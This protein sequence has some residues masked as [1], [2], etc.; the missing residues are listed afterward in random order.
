MN[1]KSHR[2]KREKYFAGR[3]IPSHFSPESLLDALST[4]PGKPSLMV[5]DEVS[6]ILRAASRKDYLSDL[7]EL[8]LKLYDGDSVEVYTLKRGQ[9]IVEEPTVM[10]VGASTLENLQK[11]ISLED[12]DTGL[13]TRF[14]PI[15]VGLE[16]RLPFKPLQALTPEAAREFDGL[17]NRLALLSMEFEKSPHQ[18]TLAPEALE[19]FNQ[20]LKQLDD[21]AV[22]ATDLE[23]KIY[24]RLGWHIL[25]AALIFAANRQGK[26]LREVSL[27]DLRRAIAW[28]EKIARSYQ[29]LA[30][31]LLEGPN[32]AIIKRALQYLG[33]RNGRCKRRD[34][35]RALSLDSKTMNGVEE[36]LSQRELIVIEKVPFKNQPCLYW[37][38]VK[39]EAKGSETRVSVDTLQSID[40]LSPDQ[41]RGK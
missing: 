27:L 15:V 10:I 31:A 16:D 8:L 30:Q 18:V 41:I 38:L 3:L 17:A 22:S 2:A 34:V 25:R 23:R 13:L 12:F 4:R 32:E 28:G 1:E 6:G 7:K 14:M 20:L 19:R 29:R 24:T 26:E 37:V 9:I 33:K 40:T 39:D 5:K 35:M 11:A 21:Q 36:T